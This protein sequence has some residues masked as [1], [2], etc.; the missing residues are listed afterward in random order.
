M[1]LRLGQT[2]MVA[3]VALIFTLF[4]FG[5]ITDPDTNWQFV[6]HVMAMDTIFPGSTLRW[7]A[8]T[9]PAVQKAVYGLIIATEGAAALLLWLGA[10]RMLAAL[11]GPAFVRAKQTAITGL[12][13]GF[14]LYAVA[15]MAI[16]GEWFAMWQSQTWNGQA[17]AARFIALIGIVLIVMMLPEPR[18]PDEDKT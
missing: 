16:A 17:S 13:L 6:Q 9:D 12:M 7:R 1:I 2:A 8:V 3:A 15:F 4:A 5:N 18:L 10:A 14:L 11:R